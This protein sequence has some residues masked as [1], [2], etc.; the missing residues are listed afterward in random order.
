MARTHGRLGAPGYKGSSH[1]SK[2]HCP[3]RGWHPQVIRVA[4]CRSSGLRPDMVLEAP[5]ARATLS[6]SPSIGRA[7]AQRVPA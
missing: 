4:E 5:M 6:A 1:S 3:A 7:M 2:A